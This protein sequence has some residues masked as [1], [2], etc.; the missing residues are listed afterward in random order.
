MSDSLSQSS[1]WRLPE[2]GANPSLTVIAPAS[3]AGAHI[4]V[5]QGDRVLLGREGALAME[6]IGLS[7]RH[8]WLEYDGGA[9][10]ITDA[11]ST[12]GTMVNGRRIGGPTTLAND[13]TVGLGELRAVVAIGRDDPLA[14]PRGRDSE[15]R[16]APEVPSS[17]TTR[18]LCVA[19]QTDRRF[20]EYVIDEIV[21]QPYRALCPSYGVDLV[22]VATHAVAAHRR[23]MLRDSALA[24]LLLVLL[25]SA[26][27]TGSVEAVVSVLFVAWL[28]VVATRLF[29]GYF[30]LAR[31][32][33][34]PGSRTDPPRLTMTPHLRRRLD[35]ISSAQGGNV[36]VFSDYLPFVG[37]GFIF[38]HWSFAIDIQRG[39]VDKGGKV[40]KPRPFSA[41]DLYDALKSNL[42][43]TGIPGLCVEERL[44]VHG[45][46]VTKYRELLPRKFGRPVPHASEELLRHVLE[47]TPGSARTYL[48]IQASGWRGHLVAT[49]F[50][51][52]V[53]L[54][55]ALYLESTSTALLPLSNEFQDALRRPRDTAGVILESVAIGSI[56]T[57]PS[58]L[59]S[60]LRVARGAFRPLRSRQRR[61]DQ[62]HRIEDGTFDYGS[63]TSVRERASG[64]S[65]NRYYLEFDR[66]MYDQVLQERLLQHV[67]DFL[68][69]H[70]VDT[71][72]LG[73]HMVTIN[74]KHTYNSQNIQNM[75]GGNVVGGSSKVKGGVAS[76]AV[77]AG[78]SPRGG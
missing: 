59:L 25:F 57:L 8:A 66:D 37:G 42:A 53:R 44:L 50:F 75:S 11:G 77:G 26:V 30:V 15:S 43:T 10:L 60:P 64:K 63:V 16:R 19:V 55:S 78:Q 36:T 20:R 61:R 62:R 34:R 28:V 46:D 40:L 45:R 39:A 38:D 49:I 23:S 14:E 35:A 31:H 29:E 13:D 41:G 22:T 4:A 12:N 27:A 52:A 24:L 3:V 1:T 74:N 69:A 65:F 71:S 32:L 17:E 18:E 5:C 33:S 58:L 76:S 56:R 6:A 68:K 21:E 9:L 47:I 73:Q 70:D 67:M 2:Q 48:S 7:R 54:P 51:R 72:A